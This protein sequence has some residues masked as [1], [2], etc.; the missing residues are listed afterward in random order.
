MKLSKTVF[1]ILLIETILFFA[2]FLG[3]GFFFFEEPE[4]NLTNPFLYRIQSGLLLFFKL[5]PAIFITGI[6]IGYSWGF[7]K[8]NKT[9]THRFSELFTLYL[10]NV[11]VTS[12]ICASLCFIA[13]EVGVPLISYSRQNMEENSKN[14]GEYIELAKKNLAIGDYGTALFYA[15]Y[16]LDIYPESQESIELARFIEESQYL[17]RKDNSLIEKSEISTISTSKT[18]TMTIPELMQTAIDSYSNK[19]YFNAH[20]YASLV[21]EISKTTDGNLTFAKQLASDAWNKLSEVDSFA[22]DLSSQVFYRKKE[23]Y[24]AL[25]SGDYSKAYYI[26]YDLLEK[27]PLD[28]DIKNFYEISKEL[29]STQYFFTDETLDK[30]Q[31]EKYRNVYFTLPRLDGGKDIIS[32][33]GITDTDSTGGRIQYLRGFSVVSYDKYDEWL[34]SFS[35][36]YAK[37]CSYPLEDMGDELIN[38]ISETS[39]TRFV[40]YVF[41]KSVDRKYENIFIG[42]RFDIRKGYA[43]EFS[44]TYIMPIPFEDFA[45]LCD[46]S[47]GPETMSLVSLY[48]ISKVASN[49]G[50]SSEIFSQ[51]L[52]NRFSFPLILL[53]CFI[54]AGI[55][56]W[57]SRIFVNDSFKFSWILLFPI[58]LALSYIFV[59][60]FR[61]L[62]SL[63]FYA[64]LSLTYINH[65]AVFLSLFILLVLLF[66]CF[67]RFV[68]LKSDSVKE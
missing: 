67:L 15:N 41:L 49:Y 61:F 18:S 60:C 38:Y 34:M 45:M 24:V 1:I 8:Q 7:G 68:S 44:T 51:A 3:I 40:P 12:L 10:K 55:L 63:I 5:L 25:T 54:L 21:L 27:Y 11:L 64:V 2:I 48:K 31:F 58:I 59:E 62:L 56:A 6:L 14:I 22:D 4:W 13:A 17:Q 28:Y 16:V 37:M 26:F 35:V 50:Y 36:P 52:I 42:P 30:Q 33:K 47:H 53:I 43:S 65:G 9:P 29:L 23:G 39:N 66:L 20:Y 32:I 57:N 19:D 46:V